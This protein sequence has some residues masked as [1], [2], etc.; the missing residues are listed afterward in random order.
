MNNTQKKKRQ[1]KI[2]QIVC[3]RGIVARMKEGLI[4]LSGEIDFEMLRNLFDEPKK[5]L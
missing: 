4:P 2:P 5:G 1:K 3:G